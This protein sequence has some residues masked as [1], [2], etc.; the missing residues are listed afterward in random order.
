M[1]P[2]AVSRPKTGGA[3]APRPKTGGAVAPPG[4]AAVSVL[5]A[6]RIISLAPELLPQGRR[7]QRRY[8]RAGSLAGE[9][10]QSLC[11][12]LE[13]AA[14]GRWRDY[15]G[16]DWG[17]ALDLVAQTRC[18]GDLAQAWRW[19]LGWLGLD[20][21]GF[22]PAAV[23][24]LEHQAA[25]RRARQEA[26]AARDQTRRRNDARALWLAARP[27]AEGDIVDRYLADRG[28][29]LARLER[30]P[31]VLRAHPG[32][33]CAEAQAAF[34]AMLAAITDADGRQIATHCTWLHDTNPENLIS[35]DAPRVEKAP[36][37]APKKTF[38]SYQGKGALIRLN[39]G[40]DN[41]P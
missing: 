27:L 3:A 38:G 11:V 32:V 34:P 15:A 14:R 36:V 35:L 12:I 31:G 9:P 41:R 2:P 28:L 23:Q 4:A 29:E 1:T 37:A 6:E 8:W 7:H 5:L 30:R 26:M 40:A 13:G 10:G 20:A 16:G 19:G 17:D 24:R 33:W 22:D 21:A 25:A 18:G 39:R